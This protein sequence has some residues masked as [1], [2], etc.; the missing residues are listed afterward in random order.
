MKLEDTTGVSQWTFISNKLKINH[1]L[2]FSALIISI[3]IEKSD[4]LAAL[5]QSNNDAFAL[6]VAKEIKTKTSPPQT[7]LVRPSDFAASRYPQL[8]FYSERNIEYD[9]NSNY[10]WIAE[11]NTSTREISF[12][13]NE[14]K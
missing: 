14:K 9:S 2:L 10:N 7:I 8:S 12:I 1:I 6:Y 3:W 11:I 5:D 13:K 4:Y